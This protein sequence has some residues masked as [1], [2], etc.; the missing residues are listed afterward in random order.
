MIDIILTD[1]LIRIEMEVKTHSDVY[2][3]ID[4]ELKN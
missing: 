2:S 3:D 4:T 1:A